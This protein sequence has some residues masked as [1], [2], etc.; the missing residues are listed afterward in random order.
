MNNPMNID[1]EV[2]ELGLEI[3]KIREQRDSLLEALR[4]FVTE[5]DNLPK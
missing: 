2:Y 5:Y 1:E 3:D 4:A